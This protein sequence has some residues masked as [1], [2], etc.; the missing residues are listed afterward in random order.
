M[1]TLLEPPISIASSELTLENRWFLLILFWALAALCGVRS[2]R[3]RR[4]A[5]RVWGAQTAAGQALMCLGALGVG[6]AI[7]QPEIPL[8]DSIGLGGFVLLM[9]G[10][11]R[12]VSVATRRKNQTLG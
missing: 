10:F 12:E 6:L 3:L 7:G 9:G 5:S 8:A 4:G 1:L 2:Y 11:I